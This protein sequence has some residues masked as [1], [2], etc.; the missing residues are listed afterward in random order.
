[1][2]VTS[3]KDSARQMMDRA[4][5]LGASFADMRVSRLQQTHAQVQDRRADRLSQSVS[6][7]AGLRVLVDEAWG[8]A[9]TDD[10]SPA[11]LEIGR[12]HV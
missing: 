2:K 9:G 12:A 5:A 4:R 7:G 10:L 8:F 6:M 11:S 1:M 3:V